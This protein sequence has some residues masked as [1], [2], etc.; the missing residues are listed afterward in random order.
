MR[1]ICPKKRW[2]VRDQLKK[3]ELNQMNFQDLQ[4][5]F[6][7]VLVKILLMNTLTSVIARRLSLLYKKKKKKHNDKIK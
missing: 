4:N 2:V 5:I 7:F 6:H 3:V 1:S